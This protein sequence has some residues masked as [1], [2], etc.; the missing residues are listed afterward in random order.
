[1]RTLARYGWRPDLPGRDPRF[2]AVGEVPAA[3]DW[4]TK[5]P[6]VP[7]CYDQGQL[8]SCVG[9]GS[10]RRIH[11]LQIEQGRP[12]VRP[13]RLQIYYD[14]RAR[15]G[16]VNQDSG[17]QIR[18]AV[19]GLVVQGACS[20]D[21]WPYDPA[22]FAMK[23]PAR[24]YAKAAQQEVLQYMRVDNTNREELLRAIAL[25]PVIFGM[26]VFQSF[27]SSTVARI[28]IV[29]I[30]GPDEEQV[31]GHCMLLTGYDQAS[32]FAWSDN[33]WG[34]T[35]GIQGRCKIPLDYLTDGDLADDFWLLT[36]MS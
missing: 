22:C 34:P 11:L 10:A 27:E 24:L 5:L 23:P 2:A 7:A 16:T 17:A 35:W 28:G 13:S 18:D 33:S 3:V 19:L 26:T 29:P 6:N 36:K 14:A 21:D 31:G 9:N 30:P 1:M 32:D 20:E 12:S 25:G 4:W 8:G 15:E